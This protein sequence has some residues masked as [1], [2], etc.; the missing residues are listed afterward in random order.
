ML[1]LTN[2][3]TVPGVAVSTGYGPAST[4]H[5]KPPSLWRRFMG[6]LMI[7]LSAMAV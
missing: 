5:A 7:A 2:M 6:A 3:P 1:T 4:I